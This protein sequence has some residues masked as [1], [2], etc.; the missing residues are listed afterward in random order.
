M[1]I[2]LSNL[3]AEAVRR[4]NHGGMFCLAKFVVFGLMYYREHFAA[5]SFRLNVQLDFE[6]GCNL[7]THKFRKRIRAFPSAWF[8]YLKVHMVPEIMYKAAGQCAISEHVSYC[9]TKP[10]LPLQFFCKWLHARHGRLRK[11]YG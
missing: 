1:V 7:L 5:L 9:G 10:P 2:D 11:D 6:K 8:E 3:L 4:T